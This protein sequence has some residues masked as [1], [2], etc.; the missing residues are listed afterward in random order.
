VRAEAPVVIG[1]QV[2][3]SS[4]VQRDTKSVGEAEA[5]GDA[6]AP[7]TPVGSEETATR[8]SNTC[9]TDSSAWDSREGRAFPRYQLMPSGD[10]HAIAT[11]AVGSG[12]GDGDAEA[13]EA[14]GVPVGLGVGLGVAL[15]FDA[16]GPAV[17]EGE[18]D[19][20]GVA[21][22]AGVRIWLPTATSPFP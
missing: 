19:G 6:D 9:V 13:P 11:A 15:L 20:E 1:F 22:S 8:E 4:D 7:R 2:V 14:A 10:I 12:V 18:G 3:P 5:P 16:E 17:G 21:S